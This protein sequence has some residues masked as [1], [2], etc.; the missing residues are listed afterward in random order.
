MKK[1]PFGPDALGAPSV[2]NSI[3]KAGCGASALLAVS[4]AGT[5]CRS[6][7]R[8]CRIKL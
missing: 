3:K 5:D 6:A 8:P 1:P 4:L 7:G 2:V